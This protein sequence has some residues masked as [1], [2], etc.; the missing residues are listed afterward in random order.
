MNLGFINI[1]YNR[2]AQPRCYHN[3]FYGRVFREARRGYDNLCFW[4]TTVISWSICY[5]LLKCWVLCVVCVCVW[6]RERVTSQRCVCVCVRERERESHIT[7]LCVWERER[8]R[9]ISQHVSFLNLGLCANTYKLHHCVCHVTLFLSQA[10]TDGKTNDIINCLYYNF[11]NWSSWL[12][13]GAL[14]F[15]RVLA[16]FGQ[17]QYTVPAGQSEQ[18][19]LVW[20]RGFVENE[21]FERGGA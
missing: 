3:A 17:S 5:W 20:R 21:A 1:T 10:W 4:I 14:H 13:K 9:V 16:V 7:A 8:E 11:E 2:T 19:V 6:E 18:T 12:C 15:R